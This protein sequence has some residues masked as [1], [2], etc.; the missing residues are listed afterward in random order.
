MD[1]RVENKRHGPAVLY[2]DSARSD[3]ILVNEKGSQRAFLP[4]GDQLAMSVR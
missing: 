3:D 4:E 2:V 1:R